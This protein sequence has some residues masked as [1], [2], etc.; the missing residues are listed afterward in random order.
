MKHNVFSKDCSLIEH[1]HYDS[2]QSKLG[3]SPVSPLGVVADGVSSTHPDVISLLENT[4]KRFL[5]ILSIYSPDPLRNGAVLL[6]L[7][8][9]LLLD[10]ESLESGHYL[11]KEL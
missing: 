11:L 5:F 4:F 2:L 3:A 7:L 10:T 9:K 6:H 8:C 1:E